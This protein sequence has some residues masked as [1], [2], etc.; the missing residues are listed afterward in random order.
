VVAALEN[1][2][3]TSSYFSEDVTMFQENQL[4]SEN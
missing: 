4:G 2:R 1:Q 3:K